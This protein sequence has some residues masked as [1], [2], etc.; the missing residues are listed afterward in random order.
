MQKLIENLL[1]KNII[2]EEKAVEITKYEDFKPLSIHW[3]LRTIL[4]LGI[5]FLT[6]GV[7]VLIYKNIDTI[8]H[9]VLI[10]LIAIVCA[11]CFWYAYKYHEGFSWEEV[12]N[13]NNLDDF[14]LLAGCLL[15]LTLEGYLQYQYNFFGTKYG[16]ATFIPAVLFL[17]CAYFFDHRG[18]LSMGITAFASWLG[19]NITPLKMLKNGD[20]STPNL[21][22]TAIG[23]G[24]LLIVI[25]W[26][27]EFK[28]K[29]KHFAFTYHVF[30]GNLAFIASLVALFSHDFKF[31]YLLLIGG[32][33]MA[34]IIHARHTQS[35]ILLLIGV[36][37]GYIAITYFFFHDIHNAFEWF[38][39]YFVVSAAGVVWFLL[40]IKK[41]LRIGKQKTNN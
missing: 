3:E 17:F 16:L 36:V 27:S 33:S 15:F 19:I 1:A 12:S 30:G 22:Y 11:V 24:I 41:I 2:S 35:Y 38:F 21:V 28:N 4:Y 8:G 7:G 40:N 29:K 34:S 18:V 31:I 5:S 9:S 20:F 6:S 14:A 13:Q 25:G 32:L 39:F 26:L 37:Y 23:L 10:A